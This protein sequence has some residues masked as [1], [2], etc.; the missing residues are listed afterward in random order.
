[1][2]K[3]G[4]GLKTMK[5]MMFIEGFS[6]SCT[7]LCLLIKKYKRTGSVADNTTVRPLRKLTPIHYKFLDD[8]MTVN[9]ELSITKLYVLF[10]DRFPAVKVSHSTVK[11]ARRELGWVCKKTRYCALISDKNQEARLAWC[12]KQVEDEDLEFKDVLFTD[13]CSIQLDSNRLVTFRKL[14][15]P[16]VYRM[17]PKHPPKLHVWAGISRRGAT[18]DVIFSG[19]MNATRYVQI[20]EASLIPFLSTVYPDGHRFMQDNNPKHTSRYAKAWY[21]END[22]NWWKTPA[23]S[24]DL[25]PIELIWHALKD[26]LRIEYKPRNLTQLT[27]GI[28]AFWRTLTPAV[29]SKFVGHLK[30]VI[31]KVIE[32][33]GGPSGY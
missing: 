17:R 15:Q 7:S 16:V 26:Y 14:G 28:K 25:N 24:P 5:E 29:C 22:V 4:Y 3:A 32:V 33:K 10:Q 11:R 21:E 12:E 9:N 19:I 2:W 1:M 18:Q 31:P 23:S 27:Q 13:E 8:C 30:K 6:V 20:L